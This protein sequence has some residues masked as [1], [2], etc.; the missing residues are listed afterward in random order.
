MIESKRSLLHWNYFLALE[1]DLEH[2]S[3]YVEFADANLKTYSLELAHLLLASSSEVDVVLKSLCRIL[4]PDSGPTNIDDYR[5]TVTSSVPEFADQPVFV[6]RYGLELQPWSNWSASTN[7]DWWK[8]YNKVKHN[9]DEHFRDANLENTLNSVAALLISV[10]YFYRFSYFP[11]E[12]V[13]P[14]KVSHILVPTSTLMRL[15]DDY[16]YGQMLVG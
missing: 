9:R 1:A 11:S 2:L 14:R 3:R 6:P 12:E 5:I 7:P 13:D 10:F 15:R 16:Y 8:C 4:A